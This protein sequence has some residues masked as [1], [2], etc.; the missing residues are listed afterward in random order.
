M[1]V[2]IY[3]RV[4]TEE[5]TL[6]NQVDICTEWAEKNGH[7]VFKTYTEKESG[8]KTSRPIFNQMLEDMRKYK[9]R[10]VVVTKLDRIGRSLQH[11][12]SLFDE[13]HNKKVE[14]VAVTQNIDTSTAGGK[15]QMQIMGA[16]A[17]FERAIISERTKEGLRKAENVGKRGKD[18]KPRQKRGGLRK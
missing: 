8:A 14:F 12:L 1:K 17:E 9:F 11:L 4:S 6:F 15:L 5:Q 10:M 16:F 2:A 13:F 3:C 7:E 18:K